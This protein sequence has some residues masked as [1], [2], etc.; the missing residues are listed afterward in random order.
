MA[1]LA[2]ELTS[3]AIL[4]VVR[5]HSDAEY[6]NGEYAVLVSSISNRAGSAGC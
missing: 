5:L 6:R 4:G 1:F 3:G 2:I